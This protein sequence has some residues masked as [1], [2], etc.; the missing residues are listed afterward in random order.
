[1]LLGRGEDWGLV[2][3]DWCEG[4]MICNIPRRRLAQNLLL[5]ASVVR[6]VVL[7]EAWWGDHNCSK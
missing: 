4:W 7:S 6:L 5:M 1:M 3:M 2:K